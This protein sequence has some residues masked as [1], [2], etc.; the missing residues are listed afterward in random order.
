MNNPIE[1]L[2]F[3]D[4]YWNRSTVNR[5]RNELHCSPAELS[6][7][8]TREESHPYFDALHV[9]NLIREENRNG[10]NPDTLILGRLEMASFRQF[11]FRGFGE[12]SGSE[13]REL[14]FL[15]LNVKASDEVSQ[16]E[17]VSKA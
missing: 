8:L 10:K 14:F 2:P 4:H 17:L 3:E 1:M 11:V 16:L 5:L 6:Q 7:V 13:M 9:R 15:G 12:E